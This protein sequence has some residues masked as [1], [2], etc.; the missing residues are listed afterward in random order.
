MD[1]APAQKKPLKKNSLN[2]PK[3][4]LLYP[5]DDLEGKTCYQVACGTGHTLF[6]VNSEVGRCKLDPGLKASRFQKFNLMKRE[7][8]FQLEP[9]F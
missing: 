6:L 8:Y 5:L 2:P 4:P 9:D 7:I 1:D 3:K